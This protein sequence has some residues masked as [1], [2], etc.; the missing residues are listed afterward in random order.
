M[1]DMSLVAKNLR[2]VN[3]ILVAEDDLDDQ[4]LIRDALTENNLALEKIKF[5]QDGEEL[6]SLLNT[7]EVLPNL[8]LLDLNMP[9]KSGR[10]ALE[11]IKQ[12]PK[13]KHI[14]V[15]IFTTSDSE[16]DIKECYFLGSNAYLT[17][18]N[19]YVDLVELMKDLINFW[20]CQAQII[21]D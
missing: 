9:R 12:N 8:I 20:F 10:E 4:E 21:I 5:A 16:I 11:E 2:A 17:K 19:N 6:I 13:I 3:H 1:N 7:A 18:P 14:P 15:I